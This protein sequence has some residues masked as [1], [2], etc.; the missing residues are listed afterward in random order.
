MIKNSSHRGNEGFALV[1]S[2]ILL[3]AMS[4]IGGALIAIS[5]GDHK[6]NNA[7]ADYQQTF[8]V[9]EAGLLEGEKYVINTY[10]GDYDLATD[11]RDNGTHL[12]LFAESDESTVNDLISN[13][14]VDPKTSLTLP[15]ISKCFDSFTDIAKPTFRFAKLIK[16]NPSDPDL[17]VKFKKK[18]FDHIG[19]D[20]ILAKTVS[21]ADRAREK[22]LLANYYFEYFV[23][24]NDEKVRYVVTGN[25]ISQTSGSIGSGTAKLGFEYT[26][27][28]CGLNDEDGD[29]LIVPLISTIILP[30]D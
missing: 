15:D 26:V 12:S 1:L 21:D 19:G 11:L 13:T 9:A 4:L 6:A 24:R 20:E 5:S 17:P 30:E 25:S 8:Y 14:D 18:F 3:L 2:I 28:A 10:K 23:T 22:K 7:S 16:A 29:G 27:Y